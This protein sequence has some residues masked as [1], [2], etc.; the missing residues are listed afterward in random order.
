MITQQA[1]LSELDEL[2]GLIEQFYTHFSYPFE[3]ISHRQLV[4]DFLSQKHLGS[5]WFVNHQEQHVGYLALAYGFTFEFGGRDAFI[6]ELFIAEG[7]RNLGLGSTALREIQQRA[8]SLGLKVLHLQTEKYNGRAKTLYESL[9]FTDLQRSTLT[10][11]M[12]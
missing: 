11:K 1:T 12:G 7:Y 3:P 5:M 4:A 10:W 2:L 8:P 6:D 9:G